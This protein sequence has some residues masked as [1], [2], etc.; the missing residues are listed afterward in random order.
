[1]SDREL[2]DELY[3]KGY[4]S[5]QDDLNL[6]SRT[7]T[8]ELARRLE[9]INNFTDLE[10]ETTGIYHHTDLVDIYFI[11]N[12]NIDTDEY[13]ELM[14]KFEQIYHEEL[15]TQNEGNFI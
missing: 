5:I 1:M 12:S 2:L 9:A 8:R 4:L 13:S 14:D 11:Y 10:I 7:M 15:K 6:Q 3:N